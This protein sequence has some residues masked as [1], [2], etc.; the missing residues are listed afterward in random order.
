MTV[1]ADTTIQEQSQLTYGSHKITESVYLFS[2]SV[3]CSASLLQT[4][5]HTHTDRQT[6]YMEYEMHCTYTTTSLIDL[7]HLLRVS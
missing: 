1:L 5:M 6:P 3:S 4:H 7:L 2:L